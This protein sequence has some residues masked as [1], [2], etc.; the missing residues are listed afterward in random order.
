MQI[1]AHQF[2][3][4][5]LFCFSGGLFLCPSTRNLAANY[6]LSIHYNSF[7]D[8]PKFKYEYNIIFLLN[9][10]GIYSFI[11]VKIVLSFQ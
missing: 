9:L 7:L 6:P 10:V 1:T 4:N 2:I 11:I 5:I 8:S 3:V